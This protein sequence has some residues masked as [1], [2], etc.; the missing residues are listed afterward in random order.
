[1]KTTCRCSN[2][3]IIRVFGVESC[4]KCKGLVVR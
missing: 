4:A 1:M 2:P 3:I